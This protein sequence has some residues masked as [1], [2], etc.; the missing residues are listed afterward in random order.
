MTIDDP[1]DPRD[2]G[3]TTYPPTLRLTVESGDAAFDRITEKADAGASADEAVRSF[4]RVAD[5]RQLLSD[6]RIDVMR[7]IMQEPPDSIRALADRLDRN[8]SDVYQ[9]VSLLADHHIVFFEKEGAAKRPVIP[10]Q[11]I[12]FDVRVSATAPT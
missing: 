7:A 10:Y 6:R 9:D 1:R 5:L 11:E 2:D 8:Y 12:E 3:Q 4:E